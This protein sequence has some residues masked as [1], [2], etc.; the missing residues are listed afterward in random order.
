MSEVIKIDRIK[1]PVLRS[2]KNL[3]E[4]KIEELAQ[5][6]A[7]VGLIYPITIKRKNKA[8]EIIAG[9]RRYLAFKKLGKKEI[10]CI[11]VKAD[12]GKAEEIKLAENIM[13]ED[14]N[15]IELAMAVLMVQKEKKVNIEKIARAIGKSKVWLEKKINLLKL[16]LSIQDAIAKRLIA[17]K[18]GVELSRIDEE[19]ER[20]RLLT[21]AV[22]HGVTWKVVNDWVESF[23][24]SSRAKER[25]IDKETERGVTS[26]QKEVQV[27]CLLCGA[28]DDILKMQYEPVHPDCKAELLYNLRMAK[29]KQQKEVL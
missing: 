20:E 4:S 14:Y 1:G 24:L 7:E 9:E 2:R 29:Q 13:R 18:V 11:V 28:K 21:Y 26:D 19:I 10:E 16:P 3:D 15:P 6:I 23:L 12:D 8:Y 27:N 17:E 25:A 5:S 22:A